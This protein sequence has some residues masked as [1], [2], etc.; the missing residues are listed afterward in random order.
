MKV[1]TMDGVIVAPKNVLNILSYGYL[2]MSLSHR[3][4]GFETR[5]DETYKIS[6]EIE[7]AL[8][9]VGYYDV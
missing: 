8:N 2:Q 5:A 3:K 9:E 1:K 7:N 4:D 6:R